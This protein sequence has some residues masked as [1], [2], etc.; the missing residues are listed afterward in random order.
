MMGWDE[1]GMKRD[2]RNEMKERMKE[3][4]EGRDG[5]DGWKVLTHFPI[6]FAC[7]NIFVLFVE[8]AS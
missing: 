8:L 4:R 3:F 5:M 2:G 6:C 1:M 7:S